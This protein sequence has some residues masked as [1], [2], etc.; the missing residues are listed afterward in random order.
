MY[1]PWQKFSGDNWQ[2]VLEERPEFVRFC[3]FGKLTVEN[4]QELLKVQI[5][6]LIFCPPEIRKVFSNREKENLFILYPEIKE[7]W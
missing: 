4:W 5:R 7:S 2:D 6:F 1:C 3:E